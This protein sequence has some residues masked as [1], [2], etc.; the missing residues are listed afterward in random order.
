MTKSKKIYIKIKSNYVSPIILEPNDVL[1]HIK[2]YYID[3]SEDF[4]DNKGEYIKLTAVKMT[5]EK[6]ES[7]LEWEP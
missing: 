3:V 5:Q 2:R 4:A 1:G 7:L 6:F